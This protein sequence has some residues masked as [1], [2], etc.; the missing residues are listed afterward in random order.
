MSS[1][2]KWAAVAAVLVVALG[3]GQASAQYESRRSEAAKTPPLPL[4]PQLWHNSPPLTME[5]LEGKGVVFYFFDEECPLCAQGWHKVQKDAH[6][7][8]GKP[9]LFLAVNSGTD[10]RLLKRYLAEHRVAWPVV[11]DPTREFEAAMGVP[12]LS[13]TG[14]TFALKYVSGS[15]SIGSIEEADLAGAATAALKGAA[16]RVDPEGL[17]Q[18]LLRAWKAIELGDYAAAARTLNRGAKSKDQDLKAGAEKLI[19]AVSE[20]IAGIGGK[21]GEFFQSGDHWAAYKQLRGV[22]ERFGG[23]EINLVER[24]KEKAKELAKEES[25]REE[26]LAGRLL[27][28]AITRQSP[29]D[30]DRVIA[31]Y[32]DTEAGQRAADLLANPPGPRV[33]NEPPPRGPRPGAAGSSNRER[34]PRPPRRPR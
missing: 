9:V 28:K 3:L 2:H 7:Y 22:E 24:A 21:A 19:A 8:D 13:G 25:I 1:R 12:Q 16:W 4:D 15:G 29:R 34:P 27:D 23:Y 18:P 20:E 26:I 11:S 30:L 33:G 32:P 31:K 17:P 10:P 5:S 14:E 6:A